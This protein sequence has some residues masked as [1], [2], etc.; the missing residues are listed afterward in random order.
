M[1][2]AFPNPVQAELSALPMA[3]RTE[4][5]RS[6]RACASGRAAQSQ[7]HGSPSTRAPSCFRFGSMFR[8][9]PIHRI[10]GGLEPNRAAVTPSKSTSACDL[11]THKSKGAEWGGWGSYKT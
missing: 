2:K 9:V 7:V 10:A 11:G 6:Q 5:G 8:A 4:P 3:C 1:G